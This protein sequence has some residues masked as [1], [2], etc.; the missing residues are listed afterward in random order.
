LAYPVITE[1][2]EAIEE[3]AEEA[4]EK[5]TFEMAVGLATEREEEE[6]EADG[7][8]LVKAPIDT[9]TMQLHPEKTSRM[10]AMSL[11]PPLSTSSKLS[12]RRVSNISV[13]STCSEDSALFQR[14]P[15]RISLLIDGV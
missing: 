7:F 14:G 8:V 4:A 9:A 10:D 2:E 1:E 11:S 15:S 5:K 13:L 6:E 12:H 3:E